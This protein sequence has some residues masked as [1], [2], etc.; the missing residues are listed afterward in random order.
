MVHVT[1]AQNSLCGRL[2]GRLPCDS[3]SQPQNGLSI[4]SGFA[5]ENVQGCSLPAWQ[6]VCKPMLGPLTSICQLPRGSLVCGRV[7]RALR[8]H[9]LDPPTWHHN[10]PEGT[11]PLPLH[12]WGAHC[13]WV[14]EGLCPGG[15]TLSSLGAMKL[16]DQV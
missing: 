13:L 1:H 10:S 7:P 4:V 3:G 11:K 15:T 9:L 5:A 12:D 2:A 14:G 8:A 16:P 6:H